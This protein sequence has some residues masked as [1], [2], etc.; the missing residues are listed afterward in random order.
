MRRRWIFFLVFTVVFGVGGAHDSWAGTTPP[1]T[2]QLY[3]VQ[4]SGAFGQITLLPAPRI[5]VQIDAFV[6]GVAQGQ[7]LELRVHDSPSC[8]ST[9]TS[10]AA[11][12]V[13]TATMAG[14]ARWSAVVDLR[15]GGRIRSVS[16]V[17]AGDHA[18]L[19]CAPL[20]KSWPPSGRNTEPGRKTGRPH[21]DPT[22]PD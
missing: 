18:M 6:L 20:V 10:R 2:A 21:Q 9:E 19:A 3:P 5:G 15:M 11:G 17:D 4:G 1:I 8:R 12:P 22:E 14:A 16:V 13:V 7:P